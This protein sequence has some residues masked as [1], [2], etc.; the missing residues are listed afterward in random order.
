MTAD[1]L[2]NAIVAGL[3]LEVLRGGDGRHLDLVRH[4]RRGQHRAPGLHHRRLLHRLH[5]QHH[6][7]PRP[8][9]HGHPGAAGVLSARPGGLSGVLPVVRRA[10]R[11]GAARARLLLRPPV[12][13]RGGADPG[14]RRGL[15]LRARHLYWA[16][17]A[18]R[19]CR[20]PSAH[21]G[22]VRC[23]AS[24]GDQ[25]ASF[26][27]PA[28]SS[29][30]PSWPWPRTSRR[31]GA[32]VGGPDPHQARRLRH[33]HR[34]CRARRRLPHR[35]PAGG[36]VGGARVYRTRVRHLRAGRAWAACRGR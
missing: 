18:H 26:T 1:L 13:H 17:L 2:L 21:A 23:L 20:L 22:P 31:C 16:D 14:V 4:A 30:A 29:D 3:L 19:L 32:A 9:P 15:P 7:R 8:D 35:H 25:P 34:H 5:R 28:P 11:G 36:A 12:H 27:C 6:L 33:L 10:R 24:A